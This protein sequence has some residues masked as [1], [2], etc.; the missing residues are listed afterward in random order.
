MRSLTNTIYKS[1]VFRFFPKKRTRHL[2]GDMRR[3]KSKTLILPSMMNPQIQQICD[4]TSSTYHS[5]KYQENTF[6]I[7]GSTWN[8]KTVRKSG[9]G[10]HSA[11]GVLSCI[12]DG[13]VQSFL[14]DSDMLYTVEILS[15]ELLFLGAKTEKNAFQLF[16]LSQQKVIQ[17]QHDTRGGGCYVSCYL[18]QER[19]LLVN[20]RNGILHL[21]DST[22]LFVKESMQITP[23]GIRL[24][25]LDYDKNEEIIYTADYAGTLY[26]IQK[27]G[28]K[29]LKKICLLDLYCSRDNH[30]NPPSL[31]G[32]SSGKGTTI[33]GDRFGGVTIFNED[34]RIQNHY[35]LLKNGDILTDPLQKVP[36]SEVESIMSLKRI[37]DQHFLFGSRWGNVFL[38][39]IQGNV[40]KILT[41]PMG[42]Q[43]EN[44]AF[45]MEYADTPNG[46]VEILVTFGDGQVY[47]FR[48]A[49]SL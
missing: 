9:E 12:C 29:I 16:S 34:L 33:G 15:P 13:N 42:I 22:T 36:S 38:G 5:V 8:R 47:S 41:V 26:K 49:D 11:Q 27:K 21:I 14:M 19:E 20:T 43:K 7:A 1:F 45:T 23:L 39:D 40:Q 37:D 4:L 6:Y 17:Q 2:L 3:K 25:V 48:F 24:W 44:S 30:G 35:R 32:L 28:L 18:P 10:I 31:W 46:I